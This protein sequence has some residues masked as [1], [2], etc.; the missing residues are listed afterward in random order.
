[1]R[2]NLEYLP[3]GAIRLFVA[4]VDQGMTCTN[5]VYHLYINRT[6]LASQL[7]QI[8]KFWYGILW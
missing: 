1:M 7:I 3:L 5:N 6:T 2:S 8:V 4:I